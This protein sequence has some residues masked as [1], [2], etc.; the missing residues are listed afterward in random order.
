VN[1]R[2]E[3]WSSPTTRFW[4]RRI[5]GDPPYSTDP[6]GAL[7]KK[8]RPLVSSFEGAPRIRR[9]LAFVLEDEASMIRELAR[10]G[11]SGE[12]ELAMIEEFDTW[13]APFLP[14]GTTKPQ[15]SITGLGPVLKF[16]FPVITAHVLNG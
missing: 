1:T 6:Y 13:Y 2:L 7:Y 10:L 11:F 5:G 8:W 4:R 12:F 3:P 9:R 14:E 16:H 15:P